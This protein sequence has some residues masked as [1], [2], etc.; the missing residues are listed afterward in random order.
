MAV[1]TLRRPAR[2]FPQ[3]TAEDARGVVVVPKSTQI[4]RRFYEGDHWQGSAGWIGPFP[5]PRADGAQEVWNE[6][7]RGFT[8]QNIVAEVID[9]LVHGVVGREPMWSLAPL[10][11]TAT[12]EPTTEDAE[13][14]QE[15]T[16]LLTPW[17]DDRGMHEL[18]Q[19]HMATLAWG[20]RSTLR[21]VVPS[22]F[23]QAVTL[24]G[25]RAGFQLSARGEADALRQLYLEQLTPEQATVYEDPRTRAQAGVYLYEADGAQRAELTYLRDVT[26]DAADAVTVVQQLG[27]RLVD[28]PMELR[29]G[30]RLFMHEDRHRQFITEQ[31]RQLQRAVNLALTL[32]PRNL[33]AGGFLEMIVLSGQM[34]GDWKRDADGNIVQPRQWIPRPFYRG[35]GVTNWIAPQ[36]YEDSQGGAQ[37]TT[38]QVVFRPPQ[39]VQPQIESHADLYQ[40]ILSTV[41]QL[42]VLMNNDANASGRS[43]DSSRH[44][45]LGTLRPLRARGQRTVRWKLSTALAFVEFLTGQPGKYTSRLRVNAQ[46]MLSVGPVTVE[47]RTQD[48]AEVEA[49]T[50]SE[51]TARE[52]G[53]V[54]DNSDEVARIANSTRGRLGLSEQQA[55][56][57]GLWMT[58]AGLPFLAACE[59]AGVDMTLA[60][61]MDKLRRENDGQDPVDPNDPNADPNNPNAGGQ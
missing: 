39:S 60:K 46:C 47:E 31:V 45:F 41:N 34:P 4:N 15:A 53:G 5:D 30:G 48:L 40:I 21:Y 23:L 43:R 25:G 59:M 54:E 36:E 12:G 22:G 13:L 52:R 3:W 11:P 57:V 58:G 44:E 37:K 33:I 42:H 19:D 61:R 27:G 49:G 28:L 38:P 26:G 18:I 6:I 55:T 32:L 10:F 20:R 51:D 56:V 2:A 50:L 24:D 1:L 35:P 7:G 17:W 16:E 29:L 8:T 14:I 9:R